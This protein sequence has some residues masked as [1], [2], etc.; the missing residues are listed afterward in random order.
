MTTYNVLGE[1]TEFDEKETVISHQYARI[2]KI[3]NVEKC[4]NLKTLQLISN[5]I[6]KIENLE[7]NLALE[8]LELYENSIKKIEN[9]CMLTNLKILDLS[10]NKIRTIENIDTLVNLEE[11][12]L[13]SNKI[14]KIENLQNCKKLR[15]LELGY[16]KI[17]RIENLESLQN[18]EEL[19][20]GKNKIEELNLPSLPKL[21]KLSLQHNRLTN[22]SVEAIR[23]IPQVT[24]L[25]LSYNKLSTII[26]NVKE[27]KNLKVFDLSYNEIENIVTCSELKSLEELWLNNN[28]IDS[29]EMVSKLSGNENL[30]TLYLEKNEIQDK[31]K[32]DYRAQIISILPQ[33]KQLDAL[34]ISPIKVS[35]GQLT[36]GKTQ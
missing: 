13:S 18:L 6:E 30:K 25:Y 14:A 31:L 7:N 24:E 15:L 4:K 16:N 9:V 17:R 8:N 35:R 11:L 12:Y 22:W 21:K 19:W 32:E 1:I 28:N 20:L 23:N 5:C 3:E 33:L 26:E 29:I 34:L 2:R 36:P 10:F 27:L